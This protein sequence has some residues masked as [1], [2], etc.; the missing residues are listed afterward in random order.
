MA[1]AKRLQNL[2]EQE[3]GPLTKARTVDE[4]GR[5]MSPGLVRPDGVIPAARPMPSLAEMRSLSPEELLAELQYYGVVDP[6]PKLRNSAAAYVAR[7][8]SL[9]P[10][11]AAFAREVEGLIGT[12]SKRGLLGLSRR[13]AE[14]YTTMLAVGG[15][16]DAELIRISEGDEHVC[17]N[18]DAL[19]G[20]VGTLAQ[21]EALGLP[22][23][24]SC[25]GGDYC[26]CTLVRVD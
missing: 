9:Q 11:S 26:R 23:A 21:H 20:V 2:Q 6:W 12:A 14:R 5:I 22:G 10:G 15:D 18:C 24:Q 3:F 13:T 4:D 8:T 7:M 19:E 1:R 16:P 17:D 25:L